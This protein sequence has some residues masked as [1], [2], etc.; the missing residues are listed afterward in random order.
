VDLLPTG[1]IP[2]V[3]R[4]VLYGACLTALEKK[5]G[6]IRPI[7]VGSVLR[8]LAGKV[9]SRRVMERMGHLVRPAQLG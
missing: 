6:G 4:P 5:D 9:A 1:Q 3:I 8:R 7:A 2:A